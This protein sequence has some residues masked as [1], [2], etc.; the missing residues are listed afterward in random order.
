MGEEGRGAAGK[1][2]AG[3]MMT[4]TWCVLF[5]SV[6]VLA[7]SALS[8]AETQN[9]VSHYYGEM[10]SNGVVPSI[11]ATADTGRFFCKLDRVYKLLQCVFEHSVDDAIQVEV[12]ATNATTVGTLLYQF[13]SVL[14]N[15]E[16]TEVINL[17]DLPGYTVEEQED[18]FL[19]E[20]AAM[21]VK[22]L[23]LPNGALRGQFDRATRV[24]PTGPAAPINA[25]DNGSGVAAFT[26][27]LSVFLLALFA[28]L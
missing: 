23:S 4:G 21:Q 16:N 24:A 6:C 15:V 10:T 25:A 22:S 5:M 17:V 2:A 19:A 8:V 11:P 7:L 27:V 9:H 3:K 20:R 13:S 12:L 1:R 26:P 14:S 18:L 28:L